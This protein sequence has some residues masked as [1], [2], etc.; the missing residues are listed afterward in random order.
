VVLFLGNGDGTFQNPQTFA[1]AQGASAGIVVGDFNGDSKPD[2]AMVGSP[3]SV[4]ILLNDGHGGFQAPVGYSITNDGWEIATGDLNGDGNL[5][6]VVT[7]SGANVSILLGNGDG[8]FQSAP[9]LALG[10]S[11]PTG[12]AIGDL[13]GDG[14]NDIAVT[15]D[16]YNVGMGIV[17]ALGN[18]DGTF[19]SPT[20]YPPST[21]SAGNLQSYPGEIRMVDLNQDGKLDLAYTNQGFGT[22]GVMYGKGDGTFYAPVEYPAGTDG[23]GLI[24]V[25]VNADAAMDAITGNGDFPGATVLLNAAG[26]TTA[27]VS[28]ANPSSYGQPITL[29]ATVTRTVRGVTTVPTGTITFKD[30]V[31]TLG[32]ASVDGSGQASLVVATLSAGDHQLSVVYSGDSSFLSSTSNSITQTVTQTGAADYTLSA[33]PTSATIQPG[34]S[35]VFNITATP[36]N[37]FTG[38]VNFACGPMPQGVSCQFSPDSVTL[39]DGQPAS[40]QLTVSA[41][42]NALAVAS[43]ATRPN[44]DLPLWVSFSGG[45][46]AWVLVEGLGPQKRRRLLVVIA[47]FVLIASLSLTGCGGGSTRSS[48]TSLTPSSRTVQVTATATAG[49]GGASHQISITV[50]IKQ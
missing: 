50:T 46:F 9:D 43:P 32:S 7:Q 2:V 3:S 21:Q 1:G 37:G 30:G 17:V 35:A 45:L 20:L 40:V 33:S 8:T 4:F 34:Q 49:G 25:D 47:V 42:A 14:K 29:T 22:V 48:A 36:I 39:S 27:L 26:N 28:S 12:V 31:T 13:N 6:L 18:G 24:F 19:G 23:Y 38:S 15:F 16:D 41:A 5:D 11:F 44:H 10:S